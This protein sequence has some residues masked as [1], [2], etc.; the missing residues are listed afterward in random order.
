[1]ITW[2]IFVVVMLIC[3]VI[4]WVMVHRTNNYENIWGFMLYYGIAALGLGAL[5][6]LVKVMMGLWFR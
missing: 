6:R 5:F 4:G 3:I 1:M 2:A